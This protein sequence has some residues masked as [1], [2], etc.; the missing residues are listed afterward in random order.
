[1]DNLLRDSVGA[2]DFGRPPPFDITDPRH[3]LFGKLTPPIG[4]SNPN[5]P[6]FIPNRGY[7][8]TQLE[9][10]DINIPSTQLGAPIP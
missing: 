10:V 1:M 5:D 7:Q 4:P 3:P 9:P 6:L 8:S 2:F